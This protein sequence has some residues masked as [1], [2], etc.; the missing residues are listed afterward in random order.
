MSAV[1]HMF[2]GSFGTHNSIVAFI[3]KSGLMKDQCQ[4]KLGQ[5]AKIL[6]FEVSSHKHAYL[7][8]FCLGIPKIPF[9]FT[10]NNQK[11]QK[12]F[13]VRSSHLPAFLT[14]PSQKRRY[15]LEF[16]MHVLYVVFNIYP[17]L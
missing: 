11:S 17:F 1:R 14:L 2:C 3:F 5:K 13:L 8:Q 9:I 6:K 4:V 7:V 12:S 10:Y 16:G 15:S